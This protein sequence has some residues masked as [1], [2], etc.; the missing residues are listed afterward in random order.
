VGNGLDTV[1]PAENTRL[2]AE[3][4]AGG[5]LISEFP[6]GTRPDAINFP[7]PNRIISGLCVGTLVVEAGETSGALITADFALE[8]GRDVFAVP[9]S[10]FSPASAGCHQLIRDGAK[11]VV[12]AT[13][14]LEE[15]NMTLAVQ[16]QE[17]Q[18]AVPADPLEAALLA[19]LSAEPLHV[20]LIAR[21]AA[22][23]IA[24]VSSTLTVME[25]KGLVR[26]VGGMQFI[27]G[28]A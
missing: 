1:Y 3:V 17:V 5:A 26:Q 25:L 6:L 13:D 20:D 16:Q 7:R 14:I 11:P 12:S 18:Q 10:I 28:R 15:L 23:P 22:L 2:A 27:R 9:G 8:Q 24:A 19:H 4:A 21:A